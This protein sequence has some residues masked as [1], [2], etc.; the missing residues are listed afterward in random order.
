MLSSLAAP[1]PDP[2]DSD[3]GG[4]F[5]HLEYLL[6]VRLVHQKEKDL[7]DEA[8]GCGA[9]SFG[10]SSSFFPHTQYCVLAD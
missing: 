5:V 10:G 7:C 8:Q 6:C 4:S 9:A 3:H 1:Q 2:V